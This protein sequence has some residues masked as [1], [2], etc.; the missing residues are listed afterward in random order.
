M[1]LKKIVIFALKWHIFIEYKRKNMYSEFTIHI[2]ML[3]LFLKTTDG[4]NQV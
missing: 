3:L 4:E 2:A 1:N